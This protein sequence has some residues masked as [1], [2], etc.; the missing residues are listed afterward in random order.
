METSD[1][2]Q[3]DNTD[4]DQINVIVH[5]LVFVDSLDIDQA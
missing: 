4:L 3:I 2:N 5:S 1:K